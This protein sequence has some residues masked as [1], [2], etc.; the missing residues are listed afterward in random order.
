MHKAEEDYLKIIYE[1][2]QENNNHLIKTKTLV[3]TLNYTSQS[4]NEM[5]K[6]LQDK[7]LVFFKPYQGVSLTQKGTQIALRMIKA[8]R[9]WEVFLSKKLGLDWQD[10]HEE[11]EKLEHVTSNEVLNRLYDYLGKPDTC[12]HGNPIPNEEGIILQDEAHS[13]WEAPPHKSLIIKRVKDDKDLLN[14]LNNIPLSINTSLKITSKDAFANILTIQTPTH[15]H[16]LSKNI[17][18]AIFVTTKE[19]EH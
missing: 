16:T 14:Y 18:D 2:Q 5:I 15:T 6:R 3:Q 7:K 10:L 11:A 1:L 9:L 19:E 12:M 8:H 17:A 4:V 13:L